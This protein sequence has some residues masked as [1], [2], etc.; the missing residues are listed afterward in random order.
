MRI[1]LTYR[2]MSYVLLWML[3]VY[4]AMPAAAQIRKGKAPGAKKTEEEIEDPR[5]KYATL[6]KNAQ[7]L[8]DNGQIVVAMDTL[9]KIDS[10]CIE[11]KIDIREAFSDRLKIPEYY[12][13]KVQC[14]LELDKDD[15]AHGA[16]ADLLRRFP[17]Y[18][19]TDALNTKQFMELYALFRPVPRMMVSANAGF[20]FTS[21]QVLR[22]Y[23][24]SGSANPQ[25][26]A[27]I[28]DTFNKRLEAQNLAPDILE[29]SKMDISFKYYGEE[30]Y[31]RTFGNPGLSF[32]IGFGANI[33]PSIS[34]FLN[35]RVD[36]QLYSYSSAVMQ[37]A[38]HLQQDSTGNPSL[39]Q[40]ANGGLG[41]NYVLLEE[42]NPLYRYKYTQYLLNYRPSLSVRAMLPFPISSTIRPYVEAGG[43]FIRQLSMSREFITAITPTDYYSPV[44]SPPANFSIAR[45]PL[46]FSTRQWN[47]MAGAGATFG[48]GSLQG[49]L[50]LSVFRGMTNAINT[51]VERYSFEFVSKFMHVDD[52]I[53]L[54]M[55]SLTGGVVYHF[56]YRIKHPKNRD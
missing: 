15:L 14:F 32:S 56:S 33:T 43:G 27:A 19:P 2:W 20:N 30:R 52:D 25:R 48:K 6:L 42:L 7:I 9:L 40:E 16:M 54:T 26:I 17:F 28:I 51:D 45:E 34:V 49:N 13:L 39:E 53:A 4:V 41:S 46:V 37:P 18:A 3:C 35:N 22:D 10:L 5:E 36:L 44:A 47:L 55:W 31:N 29:N 12:R 21:V 8:Y 1:L 24:L 11:E 50:G 38:V 23:S